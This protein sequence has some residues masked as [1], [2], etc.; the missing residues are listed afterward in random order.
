[1]YLDQ[2]DMTTIMKKI[3]RYVFIMLKYNILCI[4]NCESIIYGLREHNMSIESAELLEHCLT[5][6]YVLWN[7]EF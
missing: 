2:H 7:N 3:W 5:S 6:G 1:M 4:I